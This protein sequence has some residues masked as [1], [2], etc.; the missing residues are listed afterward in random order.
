MKMRLG[1]RTKFALVLLL[2]AGR[3][4]LPCAHAQSHQDVG[5]AGDPLVV[6]TAVSTNTGDFHVVAGGNDIWGTADHFHFVYE[7]RTEDF[8]VAVR[9]ESLQ[10]VD[11]YSKAGLMARETLAAGSRHVLAAVNPVGPTIDGRSGGLGDNAY[12]FVTRPTTDAASTDWFLPSVDITA[13]AYPNAWI[14]LQRQGNTFNG[15]RGSDGVNWTLIGQTTQALSATLF[16][17]LA[18]TPRNNTNG[19]TVQAHYRSYSGF[20]PPHITT[21]PQSVVA[22]P[23]GTAT[24]QVAASGTAPLGFQWRKGGLPLLGSTATSLTFS[25][26]QV[27]DAGSYDVVVTNFSG[28]ST[29]A[30]ATFTITAPTLTVSRYGGGT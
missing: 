12:D 20:S 18:T 27:S 28:S 26:V 22:M 10:P 4:G 13:L 15:Y 19:Y 7:P 8:D 2:L 3:P 5:T 16:L 6:G 17:G 23:G 21:Q 9:V 30:P 29:S 14:R 1:T 24:L 11:R 25:P